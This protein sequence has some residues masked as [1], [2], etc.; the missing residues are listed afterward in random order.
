M[1]S[2]ARALTMIDSIATAGALSALDRRGHQLAS[3]ERLVG[4]CQNARQSALDRL[5]SIL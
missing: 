1:G 5:A 2:L 4:P 3:L